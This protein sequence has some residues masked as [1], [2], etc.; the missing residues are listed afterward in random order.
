V[1]NIYVCFY[2]IGD[3]E[4]HDNVSGLSN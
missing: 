4:H 3:E 1:E 2:V